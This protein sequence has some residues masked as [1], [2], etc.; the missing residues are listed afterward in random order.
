MMDLVQQHASRHSRALAHTS[1]VYLPRL[2][3]GDWPCSS[4][5]AQ[6]TVLWLALEANELILCEHHTVIL[7][8]DACLGIVFLLKGDQELACKKRSC[9]N[10]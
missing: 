3:D 5:R 9:N 1:L 4:H 2:Q 7:S 6:T 10:S 8:K